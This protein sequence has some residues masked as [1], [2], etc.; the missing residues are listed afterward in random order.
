LASAAICKN[1]GVKSEDR[2]WMYKIRN[3]K[4]LLCYYYQSKVSE[5]LNFAF[6]IERVVKI[7]TMGSKVVFHI[8]CP[9]SKCKIKVFNER[10]EVEYDL[11]H[12]GFIRGYKTW[13]AHGE[14][15]SKPK[16]IG[17]YSRSMK[18]DDVGEA[19]DEP[20]YE[21]CQ[22]YSTLEAATRLLNWKAQ[23][24]V[25][26]AAYNRALSI[27]KD[28]LPGTK[29]VGNFYETKKIL[30]KP[31]LPREKIHACKSHL[32]LFYGKVDSLLSKCKVCAYSRYKNGRKNN[33]PNLVL[34]YFPIAPRLQRMYMSKKMSKEMTWHH[35]HKK[36]SNKMDENVK[37][38]LVIPG[39]KNPGQ[40]ID[41][42]LQP[43]IK[44]L[45]MLWNSSVETYDAYRKNN[46]HLKAALLWT[47]SDF[48]AYAML[49]RW[50]THDL[51]KLQK[52]IVET[53]CKLE[54]IFPPELFD[55]MEHL[56]IH[57]LREAL[58]GGPKQYRWMYIYERK[59][60]SLKRTVRNKVRVEG[61]IIESYLVKEL[62]M[63]CS[64]YFDPRIET[65]LN[66]E[67]RNF[68]PDIH[69]SSQADSRLDIF[70]VPSRRLFDT[71][72]KRNLTNAEKYKAH[73]YILLNCEDVHPFLRLIDKYMMQEDPY[74][75]EEILDR[76]RDEKFAQWFKEHIQ[77]NDGNEHLKVLA[78]GPMRYV[79]SYKGYFVN[80][81]KFHILKHGDGR[82]THNSGVC[83]KGS[84]YN[85]FEYDYYGLLVDVLEVNYG[86][87]NGLCVVVLFK[88]DWFE[89]IQGVRVNR[90][91]NLVDVKYKSKGFQNDP[92]ILASQAEQVYYAPYPLMTKDLK[93][94][95][96][97]VK[98]T[99]RNIYEVT[100]C[101]SEV[102]D[103]NVDV[104]DFFQENKMP[105]CS[106]TADANKNDEAISLV[107]QGEMEEVSDLD[108]G[109][110]YI[111][112]EN[113]EEFVDIYDDS[114]DDTELNLSGHSS[115]EDE[116][117]LSNN[118]SDEDEV[119]ESWLEITITED[120]NFDDGS[121]SEGRVEV[122]IS[123]LVVVVINIGI[124]GSSNVSILGNQ[125]ANCDDG[126]RSGGRRMG[127]SGNISIEGSS[128]VSELGNQD[129]NDD[130]G[131]RSG[132]GGG[133]K[134]RNIG[135]G[136]SSN[137][138]ILGN[139]DANFDDGSRSGGIGRGRS[140]NM[141]IGGS[142]NV[143]IL[144]NQDAN[145][146]DGSR[147]GG[148]GRGRSGNMGIG[149]SSNVSVLVN[150][151][152]N[153]DDGSRSGGRRR[154]RSRNIGIGGSSNVSGLGNNNADYLDGSRNY[155]DGNR[156]GGMGRGRSG[157]IG[158]SGNSN[159]SG[160]GNHERGRSGNIGIGGSSNVSGFGNQD[161]NYDCDNGS[162][163]RGRGRSRNIGGR[164]SC[165]TSGC[166]NP[167]ADYD[168]ND[169]EAETSQHD[170]YQ[171]Y[172]SKNAAVYRA[173]EKV[174]SSRFSDILD[175]PDMEDM[176]DMVWNTSRWKKKSIIARQN[177]LSEVDGEVSKHIAGS[178][179]IL[180]HKFKMEK[181]KKRHVSLLEAY[182]YTHTQETTEAL[183]NGTYE[184]SGDGT[185]E[186][187]VSETQEYITRRAKRVAD[188]A[189]AAIEDEH[190]PDTSQHPP[191]NFDL[192]GKATRGKKKGA[193]LGRDGKTVARG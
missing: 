150:Q 168:A 27:F 54:K 182:Q 155:H 10:N 78:R 100:Q 84:T 107:A 120:A 121:R 60:G 42:F 98:A 141:G 37:L 180:Q 169:N 63:N 33:V 97:V 192:W 36:D 41:V 66:R 153:Y 7:R 110:A 179:T 14:R 2:G 16:E 79:E 186:A 156:S 184:G 189:E 19:D 45:K 152:A 122:E 73:T 65:R 58:L 38:S 171:W 193:K 181:Q 135:I 183:G 167:N 89:P 11:W 68:A 74:I 93:D 85:E 56:V 128:N 140:G 29:L 101:S 109:D 9:C 148:R 163:S 91:H 43:L 104:E 118:S 115:D 22:K 3:N 48:P 39:K 146:D 30:R 116:V 175:Q 21:G 129:E 105:I 176:I 23:C 35:D 82:V 15:K 125:D 112:S 95:W 174:M 108:V 20:L 165:S 178:I 86:D 177:R 124:G 53:I 160:L 158:I 164:G 131:S 139:Q 142:S 51:E 50:S 136:G 13:Y 59:L 127:R 190:G 130:D 12:N 62:S 188:A 159:V 185:D 88:C 154:A 119:D 102:I 64:L 144:G 5:F 17:Q 25:P 111:V 143:S 80:G 145:F 76:A 191:N 113:D 44:E 4:G 149:G 96:A 24:N 47:V 137:V 133:G 114:D 1:R 173:W 187:V 117:D 75:D 28:M 52:S 31:D 32:M 151:D 26:K 72:T 123:A 18:V 132:G 170:Q 69:C 49:S 83:V 147:S 46:F 126:S 77:S 162:I 94:W 34:T 57:L 106:N 87:S 138:S 92:F 134:S 90:K 40:N 161:V 70:K 67:P 55:L 172:P 99:A 81:Y 8:K 166:G 157:N 6:S 103:D 71:R 61:S